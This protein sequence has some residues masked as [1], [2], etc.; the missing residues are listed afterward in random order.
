LPPKN[1]VGRQPN[2]GMEGLAI[3]ADGRKLFG[4]MQNP[5]IQ[6]GALN[7]EKQRIGLNNRLLEVDIA[8]GTTKEFVYQLEDPEAGVSEII[9]V[10][11]T[12]FLV[13]ERDGKAGKDA[14]IKKLF[15][16]DLA[17]ATDVSKVAALPTRGLPA[18]IKQVGKKLFLDFLDP[19]Y[20]L[21]GEQLPEKLEGLAFGPDLPDGRRLLIVTADNDFVAERPFHVYAFAIDCGELPAFQ[22]QRIDRSLARGE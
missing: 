21:R 11:G 22:A 16:I 20:K 4:L 8:T 9:A 1:L 6:D 2:K 19:K 17:G 15:R 14:K 12:E 18:S 5:L 10:G 3:S 13:L 7:S